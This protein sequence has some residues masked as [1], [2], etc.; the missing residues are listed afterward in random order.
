M[1]RPLGLPAAHWDHE[2]RTSGTGP[3]R[4]CRR[5]VGRAAHGFFCRQDA[6]ST[7]RFMESLLS[8]FECIGTLNLAVGRNL[9]G[10]P[11]SGG[12]DRL[13]PGHQTVGSWKAPTTF[14]PCIGTLNRYESPS[15]GLRPPSPPAQS[16]GEG[17]E[18][19][20]VHGKPPRGTFSLT[21]GEGWDERG[22]VHGKPPF[23]FPNALGP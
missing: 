22:T 12:P 19:G 10:V 18:R 13:K 16:G 8:F 21:W 15:P 11:P 5:L 14:V 9:F 20:A 17:R 4:C 3:P 2:P 6:G 7:L 23:V 1:E